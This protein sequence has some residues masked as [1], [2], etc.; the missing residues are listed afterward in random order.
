M[1]MFVIYS[2]FVPVCWALKHFNINY[3]KCKLLGYMHYQNFVLTAAIIIWTK[4][5]LK[6]LKMCLIRWT[7]CTLKWSYLLIVSKG[8]FP[9]RRSRVQSRSLFH[10]TNV[11]QGM[12]WFILFVKHFMVLKVLNQFWGTINILNA[13]NKFTCEC[14]FLFIQFLCF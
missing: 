2:S 6:L 1:K 4:I 9:E 5:L 14:S 3:F 11:I 8:I 13:W 10:G 7:I 12:V